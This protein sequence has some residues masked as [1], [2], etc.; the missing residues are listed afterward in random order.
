VSAL[1]LEA[2][3]Q[4]FGIAGTEGKLVNISADLSHTGKLDLGVLKKFIGGDSMMLEEKYKAARQFKPTARLVLATNTLPKLG[5][6]TDAIWRRIDVLPFD[7]QVAVDQVNR[8][9]DRELCEERDAIFQFMAD[10]LV[11]LRQQG[12]FTHSARMESAATAY[13]RD[14]NPTQ[15]Y[16]R[17]H[18]KQEEGAEVPKDSLYQ[19]YCLAMR[20]G[21]ESLITKAQLGQE[22]LRMFPATRTRRASEGTRSYFYTNLAPHS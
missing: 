10:G 12:A 4:R 20:A 14:N 6:P 15:E 18:W 3:S 8:D 13:R 19:H 2:L 17:N 21:G 7:R 11:R 9:L 5:D 22:I 16:L 1:D